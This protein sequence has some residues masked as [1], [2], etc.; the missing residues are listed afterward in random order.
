MQE[1]IKG[2]SKSSNSQEGELGFCLSEEFQLK[3]C[4]TTIQGKFHDHSMLFEVL[5]SL[6]TWNVEEHRNG[7]L[8]SE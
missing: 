3:G 6:D 5:K 8:L 2:S 1:H 4:S 7:P